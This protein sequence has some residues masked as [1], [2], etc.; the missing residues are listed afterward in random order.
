[1]TDF[2]GAKRDAA[3]Q[4]AAWSSAERK[5]LANNP[6]AIGEAI[7]TGFIANFTPEDR[8]ALIAKFS[9]AGAATQ[10]KRARRPLRAPRPIEPATK[11]ASSRQPW[12]E[13]EFCRA[14]CSAISLGATSL[15][16]GLIALHVLW[17]WSPLK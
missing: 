14:L 11:P 5:K 6:V 10:M 17:I 8:E 3:A 15:F 9:A 13:G 7:R 2:R 16:L 4:H 1:M 12:T